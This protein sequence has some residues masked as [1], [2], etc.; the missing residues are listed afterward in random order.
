MNFLS[1]FYFDRHCDDPHLVLG[2]VL[3]DLVKNARK[4]WNLQPERKAEEFSTGFQ[5]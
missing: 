2:A 3:P 1:H 4:D 5:S